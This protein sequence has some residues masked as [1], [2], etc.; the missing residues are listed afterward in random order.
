MWESDWFTITAGK[1]NTF[2]HD[3]G[4]QSPWQCKPRLALQVK[5]A[6]L[7]WQAGDII[8]ADGS[9]F[10]GNGANY[11]LGWAITVAE[12]TASVSFGNHPSILSNA[13]NGGF[14]A[15]PKTHVLGKLILESGE[16]SGGLV[17]GDGISYSLEE[18][19]TGKYWFDGK[20]IYQ[21]S[22]WSNAPGVGTA[23]IPHGVANIDWPVTIFG[24]QKHNHATYG[25][26]YNPIPDPTTTRTTTCYNQNL[27]FDPV[28]IYW[29]CAGNAK[30]GNG[31]I[32][33]QSTC[34]D[35]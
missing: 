34:T 1:S 20:K 35:R 24:I 19:W 14:G 23:T 16:T 5:T 15:M 12:N 13:K 25:L 33:I 10:S 9:N 26:R 30:P 29:G 21:K 4:M 7:G 6:A 32:T 18:Q 3:L 28:N 2:T 8:F 22:V 17:G 31:Y 11:E 27:V